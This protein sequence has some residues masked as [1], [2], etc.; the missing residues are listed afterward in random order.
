MEAEDEYN[1]KL[2]HVRELGICRPL[3]ELELRVRVTV[4]Y[5]PS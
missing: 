1:L 5:F 3:L 2:Q 4:Q